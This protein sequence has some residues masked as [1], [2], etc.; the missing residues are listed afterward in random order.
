[1]RLPRARVSGPA[2]PPPS[3]AGGAVGGHCRDS[4]Q[5]WRSGSVVQGVV[6]LRGVMIWH[7]CVGGSV[8][9]DLGDGDGD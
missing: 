2:S 9:E 8:G 4:G 7:G 3:A 1:M 6:A 5:H